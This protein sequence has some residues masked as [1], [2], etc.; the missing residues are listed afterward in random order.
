MVVYEPRVPSLAQLDT[1]IVPV[2]PVRPLALEDQ[3]ALIALAVREPRLT[4]ERL[5]EL[6]ALAASV[7]G[8]EGHAGPKVTRRVLGVA[9]WLLGRRS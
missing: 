9:H 5:D 4:R 8:D 7:S 6:A 3:A 2:V 1:R